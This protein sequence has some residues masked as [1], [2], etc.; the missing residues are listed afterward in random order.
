MALIALVRDGIAM[1]FLALGIRKEIQAA[2]EVSVVPKI[3]I[4]QGQ[5]SE[6]K[7]G[8]CPLDWAMGRR[9]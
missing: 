4:G 5:V 3:Q 7:K 1:A 9:K 2:L 8:V 6:Y